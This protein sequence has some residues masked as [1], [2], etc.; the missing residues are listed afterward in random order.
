MDDIKII[1][2]FC[3]IE[4]T[5]LNLEHKSHSLA[6]VTDA[7]V[8]LVAVVASIYFQ[9]HHQNALFVMKGMGYLTKPLSV[10]R[11]CRRLHALAQWLEYIV[12]LVGQLFAKGEAFIIDSMPIPV[13]KRVRAFRCR[14]IKAAHPNGRH[15]FGKCSAKKWLFY[16]WRLHLICTPQGVP[17]AFQLL[18]AAFHDLTPIYELT[19]GLPQGASVYADKGYI[20][21]Y[22]KRQ[23]RPTARRPHG[24]W[25]VAQHKSNMKPNTFLE[26][27]GLKQYRKG[28]ETANSQLERMGIQR[29]HARTNEGFSI[30][31][32]ASLFA[33]AC[34]NII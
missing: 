19:F 24:V 17:V 34:I 6:Q 25:L 1:T 7:E 18:P 28:I 30:K 8:L 11:F 20:S 22:V 13:C 4:D 21:A 27:C 29:L 10:S 26:W 14:K 16:G 3:I 5:M 31:V 23:L 9:N 12:D 32:L 33:L 2:A 15:F